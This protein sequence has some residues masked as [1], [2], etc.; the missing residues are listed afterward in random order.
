MRQRTWNRSLSRLADGVYC[1]IGNNT[2]ILVENRSHFIRLPRCR[3]SCE[4]L[5]GREVNHGSC[6]CCDGVDLGVDLVF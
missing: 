6:S 4:S 3:K 2:V 5:T 1:E